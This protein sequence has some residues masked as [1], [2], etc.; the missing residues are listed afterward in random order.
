GIIDQF[1][2]PLALFLGAS[3]IWIGVLNF[4]RNS[5]VAIMQINSAA[6][7]S[8]I[9]SRKKF[10]T[11]SVLTA[12]LLWLPTYLVPFLFGSW[13]VPIF[14]IMFTL[15]S[16]I[17][18]LATPAWAS[19][20]SEYIPPNR[21]GQ[22]FGWRGT[23][24]GLVYSLSVL[25][26]GLV[27]YF[28]H[29]IS[30]FWGFFI[31]M[32][33]AA[34]S[35]FISW[36]FLTRLYEP[37]WKPQKT[38]QFTFFQFVKRLPVSNFARFAV[39]VSLFY[40]FVAL[41]SPFFAVYLLRDLKF[42]YLSFTLIMGAAAFATMVLQNYWGVF[43]DKY[44]NRKIFLLNA[45]FISIIP[46]LWIFSTDK[47]YLILIQLIAGIGWAGFNLASANFIYD[48]AIT[49]KR[50]RC[51]SYY[52]FLAGLGL[53]IGALLGGF[54]YRFLPPLWGSSFFTLLIISALGRFLTAVT[55]RYTVKEVKQVENV[56][57]RML[58]Y[59]VSGIRAFGLLSRELTFIKKK[60]PTG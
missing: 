3:G 34:I 18:M 27:L 60:K 41:V 28:F 24:L 22:Y 35:R 25:L 58:L 1:I 44:G 42:D 47:P 2:T 11:L 45:L 37:D 51:L 43:A 53:G 30:L 5:F 29:N 10:I 46:L 16:S 50:E 59:D 49:A 39:L 6:I 14:I 54:L 33:A 9:G 52:N 31:L 4:V 26:A 19:L 55:M 48:A 56:R 17:N 32:A 38:D 20:I 13:K 7:T 36:T 15:T 12:A 40:V 21:R 23:V 8:R 57:L